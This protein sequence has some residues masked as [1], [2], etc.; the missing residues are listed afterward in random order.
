MS[1]SRYG[2]ICLFQVIKEVLSF[3]YI[4]LWVFCFF[5]C[6]FCPR[7]ISLYFLSQRHSKPLAGT[8]FSSRVAKVQEWQ[9]LLSSGQANGL[10]GRWKKFAGGGLNLYKV[11]EIPL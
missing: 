8:K 9:F 7:Q 2:L 11:R 10:I 4:K 1:I 5:L 6:C 3:V